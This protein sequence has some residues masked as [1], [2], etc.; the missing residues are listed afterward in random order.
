MVNSNENKMN[1][2]GIL[3]SVKARLR[4]NRLGELLVLNGHLSPIELKNALAT[5]KNT[6]QQLGHLLVTNNYVSK[7]TIHRTLAEQMMLRLTMTGVTVLIALASMGFA[8]KA[9]AGQIKDV[10]ASISLVQASFNSVSAHPKLFGSSEKK[11]RSL[12]AFTKWTGMFKRFDVALAQPSNQ[13][14]IIQLKAELKSLQGLPL[15]KMASRV[16]SMMNAK[17]YI[18]DAKNYGK[19]DY[20]ATP[21]EFLKRGGDC[22][23]YA[24]AKYTA[25]RMLGVPESR[26]RIVILQDLHKNIP[27]A[28]LTLYTD[29]GAMIL[30]NQMKTMVK[31]DSIKHYKPIFSI[32]QNAW[33]LHTAP[34][35]NVTVVASAAR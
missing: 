4:K 23:D 31:A 3:S 13:S 6:G 10:P 11:S 14:E 21:V 26:M 34:R 32:N 18:S 12:K 17:R 33:W 20:W 9:K 25:L 16:N 35:G 22:E 7:Y 27:H 24:I 8:K 5:S 15:N 2:S 19:N 29:Q 1:Y 28:V 30:D